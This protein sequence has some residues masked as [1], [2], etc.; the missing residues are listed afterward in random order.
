MSGTKER[1]L[2]AALGLFA[3][4]GYEAVSVS[5]IANALGMTKGALYKHFKSKRDVFE[6]IV[7]RMEQRD[8]E[9][10]NAHGVPEGPP[11]DMGDAYRSAKIDHI[12]AF[13][14]AMFRYWTEDDF[15]SQFRRMLTLEQFR[16]TEMGG[17]YQQY[18]AS[19]PLDYLTELFAAIGIPQPRR[20]AAELYAPMFLL[21][22][23]YDGAKDK[24]PVRALLDEMLDRAREHLEGVRSK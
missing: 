18:L 3:R 13:G 5:D 8:A 20:E 11:E 16:D 19:G 12:V 7:V 17:L 4:D 14:K 23:V 22:S 15:A 21:Y 1:I 2:L 24:E 9:Q 10:A 6:S